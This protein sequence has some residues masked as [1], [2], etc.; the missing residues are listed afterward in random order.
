MSNVLTYNPTLSGLVYQNLYFY[1]IGN[2]IFIS[3]RGI[4]T[5]IAGSPY[6]L[7]TLGDITNDKFL[8]QNTT[9]INVS[10]QGHD[11]N[12][13]L[14]DNGKIKVEDRSGTGISNPDYVGSFNASYI[15]L[16]R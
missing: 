5:N 3:G 12:F 14:Y 7:I 15:A 16:N 10:N 9:V 8:P 1:R 11:F 2:I 6:S 4:Y 13:Y